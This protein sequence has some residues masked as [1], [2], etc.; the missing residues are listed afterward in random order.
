VTLKT[1]TGPL[2]TPQILLGSCLLETPAQGSRDTD[3][4]S[5]WRKLLLERVTAGVPAVLPSGGALQPGRNPGLA[6]RGY[7][8]AA[9][10]GRGQ[11]VMLAQW[12]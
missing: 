5:W 4:C 9:G 1:P 6:L 10:Q 12:L 11:T 2:A 3:P 7:P 8:R